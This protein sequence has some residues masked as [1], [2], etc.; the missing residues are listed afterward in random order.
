MNQQIIKRETTQT[1]VFAQKNLKWPADDYRKSERQSR[2]EEW[3]RNGPG[4][5]C[6]FIRF[7]HYLRIRYP[8]VGLFLSFMVFCRRSVLTLLCRPQLMPPWSWTYPR[9]FYTS[10]CRCSRKCI[11]WYPGI[12]REIRPKHFCKIPRRVDRWR[13]WFNNNFIPNGKITLS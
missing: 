11:V 8:Y 2:V 9:T 12:K 5:V 7:V 1:R 10:L 4:M 3:S 13:I 6:N